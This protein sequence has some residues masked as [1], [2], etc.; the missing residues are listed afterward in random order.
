MGNA[1]PRL[2]DGERRPFE[3]Q[4]KIAGKPMSGLGKIFG[5]GGSKPQA[6]VVIPPAPPPPPTPMPDIGSPAALEA[7]RKRR[8]MSVGGREATLLDGS[9]RGTKLGG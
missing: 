2:R 4:G 9:T 5:G 6:P 1:V 3:D 8:A 7:A